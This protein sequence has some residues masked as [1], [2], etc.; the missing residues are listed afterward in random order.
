MTSPPRSQ[1]LARTDHAVDIVLC[2]DLLLPYAPELQRPLART[3]AALLRASRRPVC[4][5]ARIALR[6]RR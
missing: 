4:A 6:Q 3:I 2:C 5:S 1:V